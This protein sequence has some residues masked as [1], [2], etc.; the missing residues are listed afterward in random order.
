MK[1]VLYWKCSISSVIAEIFLHNSKRIIIST[2][3]YL[4]I[5]KAVTLL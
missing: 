2:I 3:F 5:Y 4:T 1:Y